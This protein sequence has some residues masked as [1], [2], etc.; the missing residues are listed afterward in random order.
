M[1]RRC[2]PKRSTIAAVPR[3]RGGDAYLWAGGREAGEIPRVR[4]GDAVYTGIRGGELDESSQMRGSVHAWDNTQGRATR[5][6][7]MPAAPSRHSVIAMFGGARARS[8]ATD[9]T[10]AGKQAGGGRGG[11][12]VLRHD[13]RRCGAVRH[14]PPLHGP[15]PDG[16]RWEASARPALRR[17]QD[18]ARHP[19]RRA[20]VAGRAD[21]AA[22]VVVPLRRRA[23][24]VH[25]PGRR[26]ALAIRRAP[27]DTVELRTA[28]AGTVEWNR[29]PL[30]RGPDT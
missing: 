13:W 28:R 12:G 18:R 30:L 7:S 23:R 21:A 4:G 5:S 24:R 1:K 10:L 26:G 29:D 22:R 11:D 9:S 2:L 25:H 27:G 3:R 14:P 16:A 19:A 17:R 8:V 20:R 6:E 15:R